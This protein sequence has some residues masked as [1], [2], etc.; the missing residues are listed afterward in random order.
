M[1]FLKFS[2]VH[3]YARSPPN[4]DTGRNVWPVAAENSEEEAVIGGDFLA[5]PRDLCLGAISSL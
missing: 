1:L 4:I 3:I 5:D 2:P